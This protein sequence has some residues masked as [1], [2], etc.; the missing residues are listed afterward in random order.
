MLSLRAAAEM[1]GT[2]KSSI[3]R[4]IRSG[5]LSAARGDDGAFQIDPAE[6]MRAFPPQVFRPERTG[7]APLGQTETPDL[8]LRNAALEGEVKAL[9]AEVRLLREAVDR[10]E[11][12]RD[13]WHEQ[14]Q[15]LALTGPARRSW[16]QWRQ[17]A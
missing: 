4:A 11:R 2:S 13:R 16:W 14:A 8:A 1:A 9:G 5:R 10:L 15:R 12:D 17:R 3:F 7:Y 6:L